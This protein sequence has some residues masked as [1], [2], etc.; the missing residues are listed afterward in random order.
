MLIRVRPCF[1]RF[2]L[3]SDI[4]AG[5]TPDTELRRNQTVSSSMRFLGA[6]FL[7]LI[8]TLVREP[9]VRKIPLCR[10]EEQSN[11]ESDTDYCESV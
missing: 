3:P 7:I 4:E 5:F 6:L 9:F 1:P 10:Q 2:A 8:P 11:H